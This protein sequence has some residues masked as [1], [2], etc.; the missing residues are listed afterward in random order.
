LFGVL[1][2][3][4][5]HFPFAIIVEGGVLPAVPGA[6]SSC[7]RADMTLVSGESNARARIFMVVVIS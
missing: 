3:R 2:N 4:I 6:S 1:P 7:A 5:E